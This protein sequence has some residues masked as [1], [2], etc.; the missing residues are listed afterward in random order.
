MGIK[1][2]DITGQRFGRLLVIR[3]HDQVAGRANRWWTKCDCGNEQPVRIGALRNGNTSSCGCLQRDIAS[4]TG[5]NKGTYKHGM[6]AT[7]TYKSWAEMFQRCQNPNNRMYADY[8]GRGISVCERW[9]SFEV[10][11]ED[12]GTRPRGK[13][14]DRIN[15]DLGYMPG[16]CQW[17]TRTEQNRNRRSVKLSVPLA[18]EALGRYEHG[19]TLTSIAKRFGVTRPTIAQLVAGGTWVELDRPWLHRGTDA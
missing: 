4:V 12:M 11:L 2:A 10:F 1:R 7:G 16:N 14:I 3:Y 15:N 13:S 6:I 19:E 5:E 9:R 17:S 18:Q 8:G